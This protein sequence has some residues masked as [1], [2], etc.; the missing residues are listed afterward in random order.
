LTVQKI[1]LRLCPS[2]ANFLC[3]GHPC[4]C[5]PMFLS[6]VHKVPTTIERLPQLCSSSLL[7]T[8][9]TTQSAILWN[10]SQSNQ[11]ER[12]TFTYWE[13]VM[14]A[15]GRRKYADIRLR[16]KAA[17]PAPPKICKQYGPCQ[18][19]WLTTIERCLHQ[20]HDFRNQNWTIIQ[21]TLK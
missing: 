11:R 1:G 7:S 9:F 8:W 14:M 6:L 4:I 16:G 5:C 2:S 19:P 18:H 15:L 12:Q 3:W 13:R 17:T 20:G 21:T 10:I